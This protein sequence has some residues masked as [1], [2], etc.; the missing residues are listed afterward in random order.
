VNSTSDGSP[1]GSERYEY[2]L[3]IGGGHVIDP[4]SGRSAIADVAILDGT[5]ATVEPGIARESGRR[6]VDAT[7]QYVTPGLIDLHT[8]VYWGSTYWGIEADPVAARSGVTTWL[9]VGSAGGYSFPGFR[10]Y[11]VKPAKSRIYSLLN[12]SSI[13]LIAPTWELSNPDYWDVDLAAGVVER[14]RDVILGIKIRIDSRTT[15]GVG[16]E[17]MKRARELADRVGLPLMTH[18]GTAP[19]TIDELYPYLRPGD[20]LTHCFT[21]Q[22]MGIFQEDGHVRPEIRSLQESGLILDVGH[23]TGSFGFDV[24]EKMM[25]DGIMPDVISTDIHQLAV[26]GPAFD[27]PTTL[28]KFLNLGM[29]LEDVIA[30]ATVNPAKAVHLDHLGTLAPGSPADVSLFRLEEG[31]FTFYDVRMDPRTGNRQL[32]ST[33]TFVDGHE[34]PRMDERELHFWAE[35]PDAQ[36]PILQSS[37]P[38]AAVPG[39]GVVAGDELLGDLHEQQEGQ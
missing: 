16:I 38:G 14:N 15:R 10:E 24:A 8:H 3:L 19:P 26:Q 31:E 1:N 25:A 37:G 11:I 29:S 20:I 36:R 13:G 39:A 34:L 27:M 9:D 32:V 22:D 23:G 4:A 18:I 28:S 5:I 21:W 6:F 33:M 17:P 7:G 35:L 2:D 12:L 30:R